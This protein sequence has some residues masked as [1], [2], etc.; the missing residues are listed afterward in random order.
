MTQRFLPLAALAL[1][2]S[3]PAAVAY[4]QTDPAASTI[5]SFQT[6]LLATMKAGKSLGAAGRAK[7]IEP[8][9]EQAFDLPTMIRVAVGPSWSKLSS[10]EQ[11]QLTKAFKR[12]TVANY[13]HNFDDFNGEKFVIDPNVATKA[14]DKLV[15]T[16]LIVPG[17]S[18]VSL[19]YRMREAGG[20]WKIVD[21]F[22]NGSI[23]ELS[24]Q[25]SDYSATLA[26]GG[27]PALLKKLDAQS[28]GLLKGK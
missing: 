13:A 23:S 19:H 25:R 22:F 26:G 3:A 27:A 16:Q 1:L 17:Q 14:P 12:V 5:D 9:V 8:A 15:R 10:T 18:P 2:L 21:V 7:K 6:S 11:D 20:T 28:D 24:A 4:A